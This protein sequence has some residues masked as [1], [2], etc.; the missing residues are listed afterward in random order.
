MFVCAVCFLCVLLGRGTCLMHEAS[1]QLRKTTN[2]Y[3]LYQGLLSMANSGPDTNGNHFYQLE[4][5]HTHTLLN[6]S[7]GL[8]SMAN[9]GPDTN[10]NHFSILMAPAPHLNTHYTVFGEVVSN[11]E[12]HF[13]GVSQAIQR[14]W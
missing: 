1:E 5:A 3:F 11:F 9:S 14:S 10:G 6:P 12:V 13:M 7:Q 8:L 4:K 2:T